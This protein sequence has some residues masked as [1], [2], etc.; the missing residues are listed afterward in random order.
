[1]TQEQEQHLQKI[2]D[3]VCDMID[4]KYRAGAEKHG[5]NMADLSFD[6]LMGELRM[7]VIDMMVYWAAAELKTLEENSNGS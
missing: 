5:G 4:A 1:M 6:R 7:E 2:K 3:R